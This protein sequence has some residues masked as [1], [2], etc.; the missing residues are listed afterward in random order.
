M[1][2][3]EKDEFFSKTPSPWN[4][5]FLKSLGLTS[6]ISFGEFLDALFIVGFSVELARISL[7]YKIP[8]LWI[9]LVP[10]FFGFA[11]AA[12]AFFGGHIADKIGRKAIYTYDLL[13]MLFGVVIMITSS[14]VGFNLP[15]LALGYI[16]VGVGVGLDIPAS[17][18][19]LLEVSPSKHRGKMMS[20]SNI[21]WYIGPMAGLL[22]ALFSPNNIENFRY[23]FFFSAGFVIFT[24]IM[25]HWVKES[26]MFLALK[27][28]NTKQK[29][30]NTN[31]QDN[32]VSVGELK[33][34]KW[35][36]IF[37]KKYRSF[38]I[39][40]IFMDIFFAFG[41]TIFGLY[42]PYLESTLGKKGFVGGVIDDMIWFGLTIIGILVY[43]AFVDRPGTKLKRKYIFII[44]S[45]GVAVGFIL[46]GIGPL[47]NTVV[48]IT[49]VG[50]IGFFQG[51]GMWP[52]I[53]LWG[54][55]VFPTAI[56][57]AGR[58]VMGGFH[59][60][61]SYSWTFVFP[62]VLLTLGITYIAY[63]VA[64]G[65]FIMAISTIWLAP[66]ESTGKSL[67][68]LDDNAL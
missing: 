33:E 51:F 21:W 34:H 52:L 48:I 47:S 53:W 43:W 1:G 23:V 66:K 41:A 54:T 40:I 27:A 44:S 30:M 6:V 63:T 15:M 60:T 24:F 37:N 67:V 50:L 28:E 39:Y 18:A 62:A 65:S 7:D 64:I 19:L 12:T 42:L 58:G 8:T 17:E 5:S 2:E 55:E 36:D 13:I 38:T 61:F 31:S 56:R 25:R 10:A 9:G 11:W 4:Y 45:I 26:P 22:I 57:S 14:Y 16:I 68:K 3:K 20:L 49:S 59:K 46:F 35:S 32:L 29:S